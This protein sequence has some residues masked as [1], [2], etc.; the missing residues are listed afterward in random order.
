V[1]TVLDINVPEQEEVEQP[2]VKAVRAAKPKKATKEEQDAEELS[3]KEIEKYRAETV[4]QIK[5]AISFDGALQWVQCPLEGYENVHI[6]Y[7][8]DNEFSVAELLSRVKVGLD[9]EDLFRLWSLFI[10]RIEGLPGGAKYDLSKSENFQPIL[11]NF[12]RLMFW[13][14]KE[15]YEIAKRDAWGN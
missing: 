12:K 3:R 9:M 6:A 7:N 5:N 2:P 10:R 13:A 1:A 4:E 14:V 8:V 11:Y 15:G